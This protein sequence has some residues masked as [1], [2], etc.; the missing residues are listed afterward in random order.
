MNLDNQLLSL[1]PLE[2]LVFQCSALEH[3]FPD[4]PS[5]LLSAI[6]HQIY[7]TGHISPLRISADL[8]ALGPEEFILAEKYN[9]GPPP[10]TKEEG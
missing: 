3:E 6:R 9:P 10:P 4:L 2:L 5:A 7:R 1:S 8:S